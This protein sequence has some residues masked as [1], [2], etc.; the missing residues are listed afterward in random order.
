VKNNGFTLVEVLLGLVLF[1]ILG[2]GSLSIFTWA[3]KEGDRVMTNVGRNIENEQMLEF[4]TQPAYFGALASFPQNATL[5]ECISADGKLCSVNTDYNLTA[6]D[7]KAQTQLRSI[8]GTLSNEVEN[9]LSYRVHC[10]L[11]QSACDQADYFVVKVRTDITRQNAAPF[12]IEK[13]AIVAPEITS[14]ATFIP[15]AMVSPGRDVNVVILMDVSNSMTYANIKAGLARVTS[16]LGT[17]NAKVAIYGLDSSMNADF[18]QEFYYTLSGTTRTD[19][20]IDQLNALPNGA[21]LYKETNYKFRYFP[22][23]TPGST[24]YG[25][26]DF[27]S[28]DT[29]ALKDL[30]IAALYSRIDLL[31]SQN[32]NQFDTPFCSMI[33]LMEST[34][35]LIPIN[36]NVPTFFLLITNEDDETQFI[37]NIAGSTVFTAGDNRLDCFRQKTIKYTNKLFDGIYWGK[38][39]WKTF[40]GVANI[41]VDGV[42]KTTNFGAS[43]GDPYDPTFINGAD[44]SSLRPALDSQIKAQISATYPT[45]TGTYTMSSCKNEVLNFY[46][47][48]DPNAGQCAVYES[49]FRTRYNYYV[50]N[51]CSETP[52]NANQNFVSWDSVTPILSF[53][54]PSF[55]SQNAVDAVYE[56]L[57]A[58]GL[59]GNAFFVSVI[60][61]KSQEATCPLTSGAQFGV[62]YEALATKFGA[63]GQVVSICSSD[64]AA[65]LEAVTKDFMAIIGNSDIEIPTSV[66]AALKSVE[67]TRGGT[68]LLPVRDVDYRLFNS[69]LIFTTG[70]L[71][72][73]DVVK[74]F[75][76]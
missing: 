33:Q 36:P 62:K 17:V 69:T 52:G 25:I 32:N 65:K 56:K 1:A 38:R 75:T 61:Q 16:T 35:Q 60:H 39:Q 74:V 42:P 71:Q 37:P 70:Y 14:V 34:D 6:M 4:L 28:D 51:S 5:K 7:L 18:N 59:I 67:V 41:L 57:Q 11:G 53:A 24:Y 50:P 76:Q 19:I 3:T 26:I 48:T 43:I 23:W 63:N 68:V 72:P 73:T 21:V 31:V 47:Q 66:A 58:K 30:K 12:T 54:S 44:C 45:F 55:T 20:T 2:M 13:S 9:T 64:Y 15:D 49:T 40:S 22:A 46:I 29:A 10:P 8:S 27:K